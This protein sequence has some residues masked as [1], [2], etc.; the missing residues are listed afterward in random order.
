MADLSLHAVQWCAQHGHPVLA[1]RTSDDRF[2]VVALTADDAGALAPM[3]DL[4][5][6]NRSPLRLYGL[7]EAT[8]TALGA[9]L[10]EVWLQ[11]GRDAMLRASLHLRGPQGDCLLPANFADGI[12]LAHRGRLPIRMADDDLG[13]VPLAPL[14]SLA[15]PD[16]ATS[17]VS[18]PEAFRALI[19]SLD[20]DHLGS[21][22]DDAG[23]GR[24]E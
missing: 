22:E 3:P 13:R 20:L 23:I 19:E 14:T 17:R 7:V 5:S 6:S 24:G 12:A 9:R 8:V 16:P 11:V 18:P 4:S 15:G 2:F 1:L 10:T 21:L